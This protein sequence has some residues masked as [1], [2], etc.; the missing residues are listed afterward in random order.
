VTVPGD[1]LLLLDTASLY[2]RA[3]F[4]VPDSVRAPESC[5]WSRGSFRLAVP[6]SGRTRLPRQFSTLSLSA[7]LVW[8]V[9]LILP[10][11]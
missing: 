11:W 6:R 3:V 8:F 2:F 10:A 9:L 1:K 5:S 7:G 4:G